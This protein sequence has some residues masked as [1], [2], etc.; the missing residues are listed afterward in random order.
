MSLA[1]VLNWSWAILGLINTISLVLKSFEGFVYEYSVKEAME[2]N[3][4]E[5][6]EG[7]GEKPVKIYRLQSLD[8][9]DLGSHIYKWWKKN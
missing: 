5:N 7:E 4:Y 2:F 6:A 9:E 8:G 1:E 3:S